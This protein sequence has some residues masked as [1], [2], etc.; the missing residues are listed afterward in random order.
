MMTRPDS[1]AAMPAAPEYELARLCIARLQT[2]CTLPAGVVMELPFDRQD[3]CHLL[4]A[5]AQQ[6]RG[7]VAVMPQ[8]L[9]DEHPDIRTGVLQVRLAVAAFVTQD[10]GVDSRLTAQEAAARLMAGV[11]RALYAWRPEGGYIP[12]ALVKLEGMSPL[13]TAEYE[14]LENMVGLALTISKGVLYAARG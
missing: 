14:G 8:P 13:V 2:A 11:V 3:Q 6:Y 9:S 12:S 5:A 10:A 4:Q 7:C 1:I